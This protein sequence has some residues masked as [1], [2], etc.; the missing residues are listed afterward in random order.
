MT[1][2]LAPHAHSGRR[3]PRHHTHYPALI[4]LVLLAALILLA[5][6]VPVS[7]ATT[8]SGSDQVYASVPEAKPTTAPT[9]SAAASSVSQLPVAVSGTCETGTLVK[10]FTT[11]IMAGAGLCQNGSYGFSVDLFS[12]A[13]TLTAQA[14]DNVDDQSPVSNPV[15]V[16]Y[17]PPGG[18]GVQSVG[19]YSPT[20][21]PAG[22]LFLTSTIYHQG[23]Y[24]NQVASWQ[25]QL[26]GGTPPYAVSVGWGDN[27]TDAYNETSAGGFTISHSYSQAA[28][29]GQGYPIIIKVT[30]A[31]GN[32]G[33]LPLV[34]IINDGKP[35]AAAVASKPSPKSLAVIWPLLGAVAVLVVGFWLGEVREKRV[36]RVKSV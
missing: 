24:P 1:L 16:T 15:V 23:F 34:A 17:S 10:V 29:S 33:Y 3:L 12:G 13:N 4:L 11:G 35:V 21:S 22:Q 8:D 18:I 28:P 19:T 2:Q 20:T 32:R 6:T 26:S 31:S 9:L 7:A 27:T 5:A 36:L 25:V 14:F 30:D